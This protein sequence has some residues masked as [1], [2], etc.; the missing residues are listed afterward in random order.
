MRR[1]LFTY[2]FLLLVLGC[3]PVITGPGTR[4]TDLSSTTYSNESTTVYITKTGE[5]YHVVSCSYLRL[6]KISITLSEAV[7]LGYTACS[8]CK[9]PALRATLESRKKLQAGNLGI[10]RL[11][12]KVE[13]IVASGRRGYIA[14]GGDEG[15]L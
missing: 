4:A 10:E 5:K 6:S 14:G 1:V 8:V 7:R 3:T 11:Q 12:R 2:A 15:R 13:A 9:P